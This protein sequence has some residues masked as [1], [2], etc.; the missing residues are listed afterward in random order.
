LGMRLESGHSQRKYFCC[1]GLFTILYSRKKLVGV[2]KLVI[3]QSRKKT[4]LN[5]MQL[6]GHSGDCALYQYH[7]RKNVA[8]RT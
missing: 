3:W 2:V 5:P 8:E 1:I 4:I 6:A 7:A